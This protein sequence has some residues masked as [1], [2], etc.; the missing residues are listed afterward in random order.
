MYKVYYI[1]KDQNN[2]VTGKGIIELPFSES[3]EVVTE[4]EYNAVELPTFE[5]VG[6]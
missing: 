5:E 3:Q 1:E 4:Q 2:E 6:E